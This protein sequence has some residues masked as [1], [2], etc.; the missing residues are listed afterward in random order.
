[1]KTMNYSLT[2]TEKVIGKFKIETRENVW[3]EKFICLRS[4][5]YSFKCGDDNK[6][7]SKGNS[8]SQTKP[9]EFEEYKNYLDGE[10]YQGECNN[11]L[12]RSIN[13]EM[14]L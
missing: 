13:H 12:L 5:V 9:I 14:F 11:Y 8:R 3:T 10:I 7:N 1:M 6:K 4:K 2:K